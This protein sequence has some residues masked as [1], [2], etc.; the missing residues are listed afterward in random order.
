MNNELIGRMN[1][2]SA[3]SLDGNVVMDMA[4]WN[5][6]V[7]LVSAALSQEVESGVAALAVLESPRKGK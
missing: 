7:N 5:A 2:V 4:E 6:I 3:R 1:K